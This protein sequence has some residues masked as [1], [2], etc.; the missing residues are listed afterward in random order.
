MVLGELGAKISGALRKMRNA[1]VIDEDVLDEM[2][3]EICYAL[4][5][6]DVNVKLVKQ[7]RENIRCGEEAVRRSTTSHGVVFMVPV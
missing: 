1:V 4:L 5:S 6:S 3:K 7:L 2:L